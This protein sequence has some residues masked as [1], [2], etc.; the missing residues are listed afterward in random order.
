MVARS[1]REFLRTAIGACPAAPLSG[2][3]PAPKPAPPRGRKAVVVTFGRGARDDE[4]FTPEGQ[5]NILYC[6]IL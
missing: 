1:R 3:G 4:T 6:T 2:L 5:E